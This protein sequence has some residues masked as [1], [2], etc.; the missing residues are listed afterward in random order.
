M[1]HAA[2]EARRAVN[3]TFSQILITI[4]VIFLVNLM[5]AFG[6]PNALLLVFFKLNWHLDPLA[7][8][9][10][11]AVSSGA[12]RYLLAKATNQLRGHLSAHRRAGLQAAKDYLTGHSGRNLTT[13]GLFLVSPLPSAQMFEAAGLMGLPLIPVTAA[14]ICGRLVSF[15]VYMGA[16][17]IAEQ[18]LG[19]TLTTSLTSPYGVAVQLALILGIVMLARIDWTKH[20]PRGTA[21]KSR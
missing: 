2:A 14:H 8:G 13:L 20:L 7:L 21:S 9:A 6:P 12:G 19:D 15:S 1:S 11:G 16:A 5:P 18:S 17:G 10:I 3:T 4:I